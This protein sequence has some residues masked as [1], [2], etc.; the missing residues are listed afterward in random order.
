MPERGIAYLKARVLNDCVA[1]RDGNTRGR[2][3]ECC[4]CRSDDRADSCRNN[5][6]AC[7]DSIDCISSAAGGVNYG[8]VCS[9]ARINNGGKN[10]TTGVDGTSSRDASSTS[11]DGGAAWRD[12]TTRVGNTRSNDSTSWVDC[13]GRVGIGGISSNASGANGGWIHCASRV[14]CTSK[15]NSDPIGIDDS[16]TDGTS[17]GIHG[18]RVND[19]K[20]GSTSTRVNH[21]SSGVRR[22]NSPI[23]V[24]ISDKEGSRWG[25]HTQ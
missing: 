13:T 22:C 3:G 4:G 25:R 15:A 10:S 18:G 19:R 8:R 7:D 6:T 16:R 17:T 14:F 12:G 23:Q 20:T 1:G 9:A 21:S 5:G 24:L 11:R 2:C